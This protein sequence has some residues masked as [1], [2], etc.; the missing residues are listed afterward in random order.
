[1]VMMRLKIKLLGSQNVSMDRSTCHRTV[2][3]CSTPRTYI[4]FESENNKPHRVN[5]CHSHSC[6]DTQNHTP[7]TDTQIH[8]PYIHSVISKQNNR[9]L[10]SKGMEQ[11][12]KLYRNNK[13]SGTHISISLNTYFNVIAIL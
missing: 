5:L 7:H 6:H 12:L 10:I 3:V 11:V 4:I 8:I 13:D 9:T 1:M 2:D